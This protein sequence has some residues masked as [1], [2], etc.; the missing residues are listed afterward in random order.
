[1]LVVSRLLLDVKGAT[2]INAFDTM[3]D[4]DE[5]FEAVTAFLVRLDIKSLMSTNGLQEWSYFWMICLLTSQK[6]WPRTHVG[7]GK[8]NIKTASDSRLVSVEQMEYL[9][10]LLQCTWSDQPHKTPGTVCCPRP[11]LELPFDSRG[12]YSFQKFQRSLSLRYVPEC[13]LLG[14]HPRSRDKAS[15]EPSMS[16]G[17]FWRPWWSQQMPTEPKQKIKTRCTCWSSLALLRTQK[18]LSQKLG[19]FRLDQVIW[20]HKA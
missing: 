16:P 13:C 12:F 3:A 11:L 15:A 8:V 7:A 1:M 19:R 14:L 17:S 4:S 2:A 5:A 9:Q 18:T 6:L 10:S 20:N